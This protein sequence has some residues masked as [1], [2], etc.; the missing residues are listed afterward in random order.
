MRFITPFFME[1]VVFNLL[2]PLMTDATVFI[3]IY[4]YTVDYLDIGYP[5]L[6]NK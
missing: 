4:R 6:F 2:Q 1:L 3:Q 5:V